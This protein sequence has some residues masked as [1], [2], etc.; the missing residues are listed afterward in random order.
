M[1]IDSVVIN[2][3]YYHNWGNIWWSGQSCDQVRYCARNP[4]NRDINYGNPGSIACP[5]G[6]Y[7]TCSIEIPDPRDDENTSI[8]NIKSSITLSSICRTS[9][10]MTNPLVNLS[11]NQTFDISRTN[12]ITYNIKNSNGGYRGGS[13]SLCTRNYYLRSS[14]T[15]VNHDV[16]TVIQN[17]KDTWGAIS[18]INGI[19]NK[20]D[21]LRQ[22]KSKLESKLENK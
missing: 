7:F 11:T 14:K 20:I 18:D 22:E 1:K 2:Y 16:N 13:H 4:G 17:I 19:K 6:N 21:N 9:S 15:G 10:D 12:V 5:D 8:Y 3:Q